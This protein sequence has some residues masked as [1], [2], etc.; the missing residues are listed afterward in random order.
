MNEKEFSEIKNYKKIK[1]SIAIITS[2]LIIVALITLSI[3]QFKVAVI[4]EDTKP[5]IRNLGFDVTASKTYNIGSFKVDDQTVSIKYVVS[6]TK[7]QCQNKIVINSGLGSFEFGNTGMSSPGKGSKTYATPIF[8]FTSYKFF[9]D[10]A[11]TG[12]AMGSLSWDVSLQSTNKYSIELSGTLDFNG[13][14]RGTVF[15]RIC[16]GQGTLSKAKGKLIVSN[17]SFSKDSDFSF[18][19][20]DIAVNCLRPGFII[21]NETYVYF[22][23][24]RYIE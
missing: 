17:G 21:K 23:G 5:A 2:T 16:K 13:F 11:I 6:M 12:Y 19:M 22:K 9:G 8:K 4:E 15:L 10:E 20:G 7:T 24:W 18:G 3:G 14:K 1:Y